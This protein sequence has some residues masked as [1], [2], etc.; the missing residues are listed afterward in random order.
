MT[1]P[2]VV[3]ILERIGD[4]LEIKGESRFKVIAYRKAAEQVRDLGRDLAAVHREGGLDA[5]PGFGAAIAAKVAELL[6]TGSLGY[7]T[8][9]TE[10]IPA[11]LAELLRV[12]DMGPKKVKLLWEQLGVVDLPGLAAAAAAGRL[13]DLPGMGEK[14]EARI[15]AGIQAMATRSDRAPL[16]D[17]LP[18]AEAI[19]ADLRALPGVVAVEP[20]GSLRRRKETVGDLDI[21]AA[22]VD[23]APVIQAF[24]SRPDVGRIL[25][26]GPVKASVELVTGMRAQLWVH[27]PAHFG[28]ALLYATGSKDHN[29]ALREFA[30]AQGFSLSEHGL[31]RVADGEERRFATET[32]LYAALGLPFIA[33]ELREGR[34]E[35]AAARAGRLPRLVEASDV[36]STL[37]NHSDWS[38]GKATILEMAE[39]AIARGLKVLAITDHSGGLGITQGPKEKDLPRQ[40]EAVRAAQVRLGDRIRLLQGSEVEIRADGSLD[41]SDAALAQLDI[42]VA[43]MHVSLRQSRDQVT[44]RMLAAIH[45]PHVDIIGHPT[46][47]MI[48]DR[49]GADLDLD[50]VLAAAATTG[51]ALEINANPR[52]LDLSDV[53]ARRA[54]EAGCLLS[55]NTDAHQPDHFDFLHFGIAVARRAGAEPE[56]II[57]CWTP[58]R[59]LAWL[60]DRGRP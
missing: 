26:Q 14:S 25:G 24:V 13:R 48:P 10:E 15:L 40:R 12:P 19:A 56:R 59:L 7:Y 50:G 8:K 2:E 49:A 5:I 43:S 6:D 28:S 42:V 41:F 38:D 47:R 58:E 17:A 22:A 3:A 33:P 16:G 29:V 21:L 31:K 27:P 44:A 30:L 32:A 11:S 18:V 52:R 46:G 1:N 20:A 60:A 55:I 4:L 34:G 23:A 45:N 9:L 51:V 36:V 39:A 57:N 35:V 54:L 53:L 37:H